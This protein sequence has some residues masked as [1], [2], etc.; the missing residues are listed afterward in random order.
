MILDSLDNAY[1]YNSLNPYFKKAFD[2]ILNHDLASTE[3]GKIILDDKNLYLSIMEINGKTQDAAKMETHDK[4]IDI[5][6]VLKGK[7]RM[8]WASINNCKNVMTPYNPDKDITFFTDKP[9]TY[10]DVTPGEF[11]IFFP[12]DG[13]APAINDGP[14]KKI[15]VKVAVK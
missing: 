7:E 12:E 10:I 9:T 2:Y 4:Y 5:Q 14:I 11:A 3:P 13:H 15:V 6:I 8:G 1:A